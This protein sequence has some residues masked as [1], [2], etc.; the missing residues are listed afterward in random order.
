MHTECGG[1]IQT[2][3]GTST[4]DDVTI[5]CGSDVEIDQGTTLTLDDATTMFGGRLTVD[6]GATLAIESNTGATLD[7]V[8]VWNFG[9]I[10]V[11]EESSPTT[12]LVLSDGTTVT[13]GSLFIGCD[14]AVNVEAG[15]NGSGATLDDVQVWNFGVIHVDEESSPTTTLVLSDGTTVTGGSLFIG[16]DGAVNVEAGDNGSG[17]TLDDVQVWNFGV[18]HVD[19][20]SSPTTT[21]VL[22]D[23]T[24]VMGGS[25][26]IGCDGAVN[27]EA[28]DNGSG[29]ALDDVQVWNFG[30]IQVDEDSS[31]T[32]TLALSDGTTVTGGTMI[33][34]CEG[35]VE[36]ENGGATLYGV[37][38]INNGVMDV[39]GGTFTVDS[40]S[41]VSGSGYVLITNGGLANFAD[42][43]EQNVTF[44][45]AG[46]LE[47][48]QS[49]SGS[50]YSGIITGFGAGDTIDLHD[51]T[52]LTSEYDIWTQ[53]VGGG[54]LAIYYGTALAETLTFAGTFTQTAFAL[55][56]ESGGTGTSV[57]FIDPVLTGQT[58]EAVNEDSANVTL[59][60]TDSADGTVT[61]T[62]LP[63]DLTS[64]NGGTYTADTG[65][66]T[67]TAA[68]FNAL[69]FT[70]GEDS[71]FN[72][73]ITETT[74]SG[75]PETT[76]D[77]YTLTVSPVAEGPSLT[78]TIGSADEGSVVKLGLAD[79]VLDNDDTLGTVT[80]SGLPGDLKNFSG[81][82]TYDANAG[83]W[84]GSA[85]DFNT[86]SFT[87]GE[88]GSYK[89]T[90]TATTTGPEA[91]TT[92]S[93]YTLTVTDAPL[94]GSSAASISATTEGALAHL[95]NATFTD[96]NPGNNTADFTATINWGDGTP[97]SQ[98]TV[99]YS[100]GVYSVSGS[101]TYAEEGSDPITV[102][103]TDDGGQTT[104][105]TGTATVADAPLT[106]SSAASIS[107]TTE[108]AL[109]H[110]VNATFTDANPGNNT[111]DFTATINW[112][113]GTPTS[114][115][116]VSY[117]NG[118][119]SVAGSHTYAEEGSDPITVTVTDDGGQTTTITGTA[120]VIGRSE[121]PVF[122]GATSATVSEGA[123]VTLGA[124]DTKFDSDDTLGNVTITGLP[125]DL[126]NF[127]GGS[128]DDE[129][130]RW[131]GTAAQFNALLFTVGE[132]G[133]YNL[134]ISATTTGAEAGTTTESYTLTV[135]ENTNEDV[136][137]R[138]SSGSWNTASNWNRD[139]ARDEDGHVVPNS[140]L[141]AVIDHSGTYTVTISGT[142][143]AHSLTIGDANA[144]LSGS[145]TL[146]V[147]LID[148]DGTIDSSVQNGTLKITGDITGTGNL[149]IE[150]KATL[151][152]GGTSTNTATF[153]G[154]HG[155]FQIDSSGTSTPFSVTGG[156]L[157]QDDIIYLPNIAFNAAADSYN[158]STDVLTVGD[159]QGHTVTIDVVGGIAPGHS[160]SFVQNGTGTEVY[161]PPATDSSAVVQSVD[162]SA[163]T[164]GA[165]GTIT[166]AVADTSNA[167]T[168]TFT[169]ENGGNGYVGT[170]S[171]GPVTA[172]NG[173]AS[174]AWGFDLGHDQIN[175]ASGQTATQSYNVSINEGSEYGSEPDR[176]RFARGSRQRQFRVRAGHG[177]RHH[178]QLRPAARHHRARPFRQCAIGPATGVDDHDGY[179]RRCG[180]RPRQSRQHHDTRYERDTIA[181]G[182][183]ERRSFAL[184]G[185]LP[186]PAKG[187]DQTFR[188][189]D[190]HSR[191]ERECA[192]DRLIP[193][194]RDLRRGVLSGRQHRAA[195]VAC[196][197]DALQDEDRAAG[198]EQRNG[199]QEENTLQRPIGCEKNAAQERP[200]GRQDAGDAV[201]P[202]HGSRADVG[203]VE[204]RRH[205]RVG[206]LA[207]DNAE[208]ADADRYREYCG[209]GADRADQADKRAANQKSDGEN[210]E[211]AEA[212]GEHAHA[213]DT[214]DA[215]ELE[216]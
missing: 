120:T 28:G 153:E 111:A 74:S 183:A 96:A 12:T 200:D 175:L 105:I 126:S 85:A 155:T 151:E 143:T 208:A 54:S 166:V 130:G 210:A 181:A 142:E 71:T 91:G 29:A 194:S 58:T 81:H 134:T 94:T 110:L 145:G 18:I 184:N 198:N 205:R 149:Y 16:C 136:W 1:L 8:Q 167:P 160:F 123:I 49:L 102:T 172:S 118:V 137:N 196:M 98:G 84:T 48:Q 119:Y 19:E 113:D 204:R 38:I 201:R 47:L 37:N 50:D 104:T 158:S 53:G 206:D 213:D 57:V 3:C 128:Y 68:Q 176:V 75:N 78:G 157:Q 76:T 202:V 70:A 165:D 73:V 35:A 152:L 188:G 192:E 193:Q 214:D 42:D 89:L 144:T 60:V 95:V 97:T 99:S 199:E 79:A 36:V 197:H 33:I 163:T 101:H 190:L 154:G 112:G 43:F 21:L 207:A 83:T 87:T 159:G 88:E 150:N 186:V 215:A 27:V 140:S 156:A 108:G 15:D 6:C 212:I 40:A 23:G 39:N 46:T 14:G 66:W 59:G 191:R 121:G 180:D 147:A 64:V 170:F 187:A 122:G 203:R 20:D 146:S 135:N 31:P 32:T 189:L 125:H 80:I 161:D 195:C 69:S 109:A 7:D 11:D 90:I 211:K 67:G 30:V 179:P 44:Q 41:N 10:H 93:N 82:G 61:I 56:Q 107:A 77:T 182:P 63:T 171:L 26:F 62:G 2:V 5:T 22:S 162:S 51:L 115:G 169:P 34:G 168:A 103:V 127:S 45:G 17:A 139:D 129:D 178:C 133:T 9:V 131:T 124:T 13:G 106:G 174:V 114:Q 55:A 25:L 100:N 164:N 65:T 148:N 185:S 4:L 52:F 132:N 209:R 117:N 116:T 177:R 141:D 138:G 216:A 173:S 72:L 24:T 92:T 86:L